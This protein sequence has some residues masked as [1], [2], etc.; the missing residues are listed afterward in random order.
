MKAW[1]DSECSKCAG[2]GLQLPKVRPLSEDAELELCV[3]CNGYG[4]K[5]SRM[6]TH[7]FNAL[8]ASMALSD[9][10][11]MRTR[12]ECQHQIELN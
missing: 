7:G 8:V 6:N 1:I 12:K 4:R 5:P 11:A 2:M 10:W 9:G 3:S